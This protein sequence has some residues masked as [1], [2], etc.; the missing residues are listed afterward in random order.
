[1]FGTRRGSPAEPAVSQSVGSRSSPPA[2]TYSTVSKYGSRGSTVTDLSCPAARPAGSGVSPQSR[3]R[4]EHRE[5]HT[6][7]QRRPERS[8]QPHKG[9]GWF[10]LVSVHAFS[11]DPVQT[12]ATGVWARPRS[13]GKTDACISSAYRVHIA[14]C[15]SETPCEARVVRARPP[16]SSA[17]SLCPL[18]GCRVGNHAS[19]A[20]PCS[21]CPLRG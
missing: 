10:R 15:P 5:P 14:P 18:R 20:R 8:I 2:L 3:R 12:V 1:M 13:Q 19:H 16:I 6:E 17:R 9:E 11:M 4:P 21:L 7:A